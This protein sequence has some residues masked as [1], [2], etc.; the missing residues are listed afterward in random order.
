MAWTAWV[1]PSRQKRFCAQLQRALLGKW[2]EL[3][4]KYPDADSVPWLKTLAK[5]RGQAAPGAAT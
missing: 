4:A 3:A 5:L 2:G 1:T